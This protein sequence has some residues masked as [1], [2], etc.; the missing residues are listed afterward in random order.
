MG[1]EIAAIAT[2]VAEALPALNALNYDIV[3]LDIHLNGANSGIEIGKMLH[4]NFHKPF[5]FVTSSLSTHS[6][7]EAVTANPSAY[8]IK[9]I[10]P[11]S[12][13]VT[14]HSAIHNFTQQK[15]V[16][17]QSD[18]SYESFFIKQGNKYKKI[19]WKDVICLV[20]E[21]NYTRVLTARDQ[22]EYLIRSSLQKAL[23]F[24]IPAPLRGRFV[25]VNRAEVIQLSFVEELTGDVLKAGSKTFNITEAYHKEVKKSLNIIS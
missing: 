15:T 22:G 23:Q 6:L 19:D 18:D 4:T 12:L 3:L 21:K 17:E 14:I 1:F 25:Q 2:N 13:F 8:L 9:P 24:I 20:S 7:Q 11:A 10:N 16:T 5:I